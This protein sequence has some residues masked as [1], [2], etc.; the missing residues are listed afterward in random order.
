MKKIVASILIFFSIVTHLN[1]QSLKDLEIEGISVGDSALSFFN[2]NEIKNNT[3]DY[4]KDKKFT[5]VQMTGLNFFETY[6]GVDFDY[7]TGDK[8]YTIYSLSGILKYN[9]KNIKD[10][11]KK[12]DEIDEE[13]QSVLEDFKK[14]DKATWKHA[15]D[16]TGESTFT[17][18]YYESEEGT[19]T[20]TCY[21]FSEKQEKKGS[22]DYL[23]IMIALN[24]WVLFMRNNPYN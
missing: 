5:P 14:E 20:I 3:W 16:P 4:Y 13:L 9:D 2:K 18:I 21:D 15:V 8:N 10:C 22:G 23:S 7:K 12:M 24:E 6:Q 11:Y 17:D 19:V 1:A